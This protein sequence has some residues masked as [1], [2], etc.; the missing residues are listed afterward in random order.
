MGGEGGRACAND[1]MKGIDCVGREEGGMRRR[2]CIARRRTGGME[3]DGEQASAAAAA[4]A[5]SNAL[6]QF[7]LIQAICLKVSGE[8]KA[9]G[10]EGGLERRGDV[11]G[12]I[13]TSSAERQF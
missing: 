4:A 1:S 7:E 9:M 13:V 5:A 6:A 10:I 11:R 12:G 3:E 8:R 2:R